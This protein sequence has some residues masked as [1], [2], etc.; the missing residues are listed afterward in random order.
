MATITNT[1]TSSAQAFDILRGKP[2]LLKTRVHTW[3]TP[4]IDGY[5]ALL[6]GQGDSGPFDLVS[7]TYQTSN[8]NADA[9][10]DWADAQQGQLVTIVDDWGDNF[11][12]VTFLVLHVDSINSK[13]PCI[14]LGNANAVRV[15]IHWQMVQT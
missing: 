3:E 4:G 9:V 2:Q 13:R 1:V 5:G 8:N 7:I 14:Y 15:E 11:A 12:G 6:L 10:L